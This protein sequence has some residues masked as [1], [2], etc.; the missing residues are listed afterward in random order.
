[1][2]TVHNVH[3]HRSWSGWGD[4]VWE[5]AQSQVRVIH[6]CAWLAVLRHWIREQPRPSTVFHTGELEIC[7]TAHRAVLMGEQMFTPSGLV[8]FSSAVFNLFTLQ[9]RYL[10]S[11][12]PEFPPLFPY[13]P[14]GLD[15]LS[16]PDLLILPD[17][18]C[19][20]ATLNRDERKARWLSL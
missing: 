9:N 16:L 12:K 18:Y 20:H 7:L 6:W 3:S 13:C 10:L 19:T 4:P 5:L 1:M 15:G 11:T 2:F 14:A 17:R 8:S